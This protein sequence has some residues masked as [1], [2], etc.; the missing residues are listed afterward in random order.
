MGRNSTRTSNG[1]PNPPMPKLTINSTA[2]WETWNCILQL[3]IIGV[4]GTGILVV[5]ITSHLGITASKKIRK[6]LNVRI[7]IEFEQKIKVRQ[8]VCFYRISTELKKGWIPMDHCSK[9]SG[10]IMEESWIK[11]AVW[12][13][14]RSFWC[15]RW[16]AA[17][18]KW[19][20]GRNETTSLCEVPLEI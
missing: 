4:P 9:N 13:T 12:Q 19:R 8:D 16:P 2:Q 14:S 1:T 18:N 6:F 15:S 7:R 20:A 5:I 17:A 11:R 10:R 3:A